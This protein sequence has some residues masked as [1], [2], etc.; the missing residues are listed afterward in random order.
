M[1]KGENN[2][3]VELKR[4]RFTLEE[5]HRMG[6]T[7]ILGANDRVELIEGEIIEMSPIGSLHAGT[8]A[9]I[10]H[11][12]GT[13][14]G[15]RAVVWVQNPLLLRQ[16]QSEPEPDVLM[17][18]PRTD[19]YTS[20]LPEAPDVRLLI[21]VADTSLLYDRQRKL[22]LYARAG[23]V[24]SWLVN[25]DARR[26]EIHRNPGRLR[27]RNVRLP[28]ADETFSPAAFPDLKLMLRDL[29]G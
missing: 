28:T 13:R 1:V 8:V 17:L 24:E 19:F 16:Q 11:V 10:D 4:R 26:L 14:L 22:P 5:Y 29:F 9:R 27:Y 2:M 23:V 21:E 7:G 25:V 20:R 18:A 15:S 3:A 12:F 6:E